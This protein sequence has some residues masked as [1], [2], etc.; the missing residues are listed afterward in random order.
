MDKPICV[1]AH[2][3]LT[4]IDTTLSKWQDFSHKSTV[5]WKNTP[6]YHAGWLEGLRMARAN[7]A[8]VLDRNV[9]ET[10]DV[11]EEGTDD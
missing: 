5:E 4:E 3:L 8:M 2:N 11:P 1:E 7:I 6:E 10:I 9:E